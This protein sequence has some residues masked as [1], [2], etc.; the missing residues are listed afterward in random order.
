MHAGLLAHET[1]INYEL[2]LKRTDLKGNG[3][4]MIRSISKQKKKAERKKSHISKDGKKGQTTPALQKN[5]QVSKTC[6]CA[7]LLSRMLS[8][9][10]WLFL[11]NGW[12]LI[13]STPVRPRRTF[14]H[15]A[16]GPRL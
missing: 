15:T 7:H 11:K 1:E 16:T 12:H 2:R 9:V 6:T 5:T 13:S 3:L 10:H 8:K 4:E 14:L